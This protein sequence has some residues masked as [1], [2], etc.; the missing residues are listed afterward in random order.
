MVC[1]RVCGAT[2]LLT[3]LPVWEASRLEE[4]VPNEVVSDGGACCVCV[5]GVGIL[6]SGLF[7]KKSWSKH[8]GSPP[9]GLV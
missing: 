2:A 8:M 1:V 3:F 5:E 7:Q 6:Y 4:G 9:A